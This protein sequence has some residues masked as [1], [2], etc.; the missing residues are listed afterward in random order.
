ML[1]MTRDSVKDIQKEIKRENDEFYGEETAG[2]HQASLDSDNDTATALKKVL[3]KKAYKKTVKHEP[4][5]VGE[6]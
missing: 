2:G 6:E 5:V 1:L 3:G 4:F